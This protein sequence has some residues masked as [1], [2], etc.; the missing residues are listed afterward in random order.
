MRRAPPAPSI[1]RLM[2]TRTEERSESGLKKKKNLIQGKAK[3]TNEKNHLEAAD[4][5]FSKVMRRNAS[6]RWKFG[7]SV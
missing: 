5:G 6:G 4:G 7:R 3:Q 2:N 1:Q